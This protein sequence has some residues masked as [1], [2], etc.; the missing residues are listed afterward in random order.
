MHTDVHQGMLQTE[1]DVGG[2]SQECLL[3]ATL[4]RKLDSCVKDKNKKI[5]HMVTCL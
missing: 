3:A 5:I 1:I 2:T 4:G